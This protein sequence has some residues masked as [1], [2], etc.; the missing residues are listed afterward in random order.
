MGE[1]KFIKDFLR[2]V[3]NGGVVVGEVT[4]EPISVTVSGVDLVWT[5]KRG[6]ARDGTHE[7]MLTKAY[8]G[9]KGKD[10][11]TFSLDGPVLN[12]AGVVCPIHYNIIGL[13]W[14]NNRYEQIG[15]CI[16]AIGLN[17]TNGV[18]TP[19]DLQGQSKDREE[20]DEDEEEDEVDKAFVRKST[21]LTTLNPELPG[22]YN[23]PC[24]TKLRLL[25]RENDT[26]PWEDG[27]SKETSG[28][29]TFS[30]PL[31]NFYSVWDVTAAYESFSKQ[32]IGELGRHLN[33]RSNNGAGQEGFLRAGELNM[34][35]LAF[36]T[37]GTSL[38]G[39]QS[40]HVDPATFVSLVE[41]SVLVCTFDTRRYFSDKS[42]AEVYRQRA[43]HTLAWTLLSMGGVSGVYNEEFLDDAS[44][45]WSKFHTNGDC[46]DMSHATY[47]L[48]MSLKTP[49]VVSALK[50]DLMNPAFLTSTLTESRVGGFEMS[51]EPSQDAGDS[52]STD[53][54]R[55]L[56][57]CLEVL[58]LIH[59]AYDTMVLA[60]GF[61]NPNRANPLA[62][63]D[64]SSHCS[65]FIGHAY[66]MI[67]VSEAARIPAYDHKKA[68]GTKAACGHNGDFMK[69]WQIMECTAGFAPYGYAYEGSGGF[70][71]EVDKLCF[72]GLIELQ[73]NTELCDDG[74]KM[75]LG[76]PHYARISDG[77]PSAYITVATISTHRHSFGVTSKK[78]GSMVRIMDPWNADRPLRFPRGDRTTI[79]CLVTD[80]LN[81]K[82]GLWEVDENVPSMARLLDPLR[83]DPLK[84]PGDGMLRAIDQGVCDHRKYLKGLRLKLPQNVPLFNSVL[85]PFEACPKFFH[86][87]PL[88]DPAQYGC[89]IIKLW[90]GSF[91]AIGSLEK[92][93]RAIAMQVRMGERV[94]YYTV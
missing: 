70:C 76:A 73:R 33:P 85:V 71:S 6:N 40:R 91:L 66:A 58:D 23:Q 31:F 52:A 9:G 90:H 88:L 64:L 67:H 13:K 53:S 3:M 94:V 61:A 56:E 75:V 83:L 45:G 74:N 11:V 47:E 72:D 93:S 42:I 89:R 44:S 24:R 92:I 28:V 15:S 65:E 68:L 17:R 7:D 49:E 30:P 19:A 4:D 14:R 27:V 62:E 18:Y 80:F 55:L 39:C 12:G 48:F 60:S 5:K 10:S 59:M 57:L 16:V 35:F 20:E 21:I 38:A 43:L 79:G 46:D 84:L 36:A 78:S 51:L 54:S 29:V 86:E 26:I 37:P 34:S 2:D 82:F 77:I 87:H 41:M 69:G 63:R 22:P 50:S 1:R 8:F 81:G 25:T 32:H